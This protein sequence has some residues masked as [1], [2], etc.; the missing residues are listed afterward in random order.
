VNTLQ[1]AQVSLPNHA[2]EHLELYVQEVTFEL[3][4]RASQF[5]FSSFKSLE[6]ELLKKKFYEKGVPSGDND[7]GERFQ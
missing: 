6:N 3:P 4:C 1:Q 7:A 2:F 5:W